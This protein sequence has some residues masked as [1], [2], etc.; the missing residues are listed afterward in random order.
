[1]NIDRRYLLKLQRPRGIARRAAEDVISPLDVLDVLRGV[2]AVGVDAHHDL[3]ARDEARPAGE[4]ADKPRKVPGELPDIRPAERADRP[5]NSL[6]DDAARGAGSE[7]R[8]EAA[9]E[10]RVGDR[11]PPSRRANGERRRDAAA[12]TGRSPS[13]L[14]VSVQVLVH[15]RGVLEIVAVVLQNEDELLLP[16]LAGRP[17]RGAR[18]GPRWSRPTKAPGS[19]AAGRTGPDPHNSV[20][21]KNPGPRPAS[22][23]RTW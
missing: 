7:V 1:M 4:A 13:A 19:P 23:R 3:G 22:G 11:S 14:G 8:Y 6:A 20:I 9:A 5:G 17:G 2:A 12:D 10:S 15:L 21:S 16:L 18:A